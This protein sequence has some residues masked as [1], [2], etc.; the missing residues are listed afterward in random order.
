MQLEMQLEEGKKSRFPPSAQIE[1][2]KCVFISSV[3]NLSV[4]LRFNLKVFFTTS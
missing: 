2:V 1:H 4:C 3:N